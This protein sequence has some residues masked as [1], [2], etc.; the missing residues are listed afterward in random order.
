[1]DKPEETAFTCPIPQR[2]SDNM[3]LIK[4]APT[5]FILGAQTIGLIAFAVNLSFTQTQ[6]GKDINEIKASIAS[7][8]QSVYATIGPAAVLSSD[9]QSVKQKIGQIESRL[10]AVRDELTRM[11]AR[12]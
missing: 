5:F 8:Q 9:M 6:Q 11:V 3:R 7:V 10:D 4:A 1:M 12:K 2:S